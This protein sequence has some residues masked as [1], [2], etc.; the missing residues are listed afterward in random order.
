MKQRPRGA[1]RLS[2][3][4]RDGGV[5][6]VDV[7]AKRSTAR[8][9]VARAMLRMKPAT[10]RTIVA[11]QTRKG[12]V[13]ATAQIAGIQAAKN[14]PALIPLCHALPLSH[15][16]VQ[17]APQRPD[18][19]VVRCEVRCTGQTGVEMEALVGAAVAALTVYDMCKAIDRDMSL[20]QLT[21]VEKHG[22]RTGSYVRG[23]RHGA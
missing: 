3:V 18:A 6:M 13:L 19:M 11:R 16:A 2:H 14:T 1:R 4:S 22:G 10:L 21:L 9:A 15:V 17:F 12:D 7:G 8:R 23:E 20:E 5:R